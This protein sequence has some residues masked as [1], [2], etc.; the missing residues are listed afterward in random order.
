MF[1]KNFNAENSIKRWAKAI[2]IIGSI[3]MGLC[4]IAAFIVFAL[5]PEDTWW[6][7][8][9]ILGG[10]ILTIL[11]SSFSSVLIW[12]FGDI[13]GNTKKQ[14]MTLEQIEEDLPEL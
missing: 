10:G 4:V 14:P 1:N 3:L 11:S 7:S 2:R 13:V 5:D 6:I 9:I 8:L 12:G